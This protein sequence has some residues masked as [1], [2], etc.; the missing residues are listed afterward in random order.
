MKYK[1]KN[2]RKH[3]S[4]NAFECSGIFCLI[5]LSLLLLSVLLKHYSSIAFHLSLFFTG[6][7]TSTYGEYLIH[8][9]WMHDNNKSRK[10]DLN[11]MYHHS[12]PTE[13]AISNIQRFLLGAATVV[14]I[15]IAI[16]LHNYFTLAAGFLCGF[17]IYS[18]M[19]FLLHQK[20]TQ[21]IFK[22]LVQFHIYHHCKYPD[23]CFG[24]TV[25]WWDYIFGTIPLNAGV[26]PQRIIDFY[27]KE[28]KIHN[29]FNQPI[30]HL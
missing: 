4:N 23:T 19:H 17:P 24:I 20:P 22:K 3:K 13:I 7:L 14:V 21:K 26:I 5:L 29:H 27:F 30:N 11:H 16:W 10:N 25:T 2:H 18:F 6:W 15:V 9:Y 12:H 28:E 1:N 8:R